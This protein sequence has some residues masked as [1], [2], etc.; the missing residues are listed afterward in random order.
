MHV[1]PTPNAINPLQ[2]RADCPQQADSN[3]DAL[4]AQPQRARQAQERPQRDQ[5]ELATKPQERESH[6]EYKNLHAQQ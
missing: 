2:K 5:A 6:S 4:Q 3:R 1:V